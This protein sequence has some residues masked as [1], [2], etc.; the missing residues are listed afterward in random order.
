MKNISPQKYSLSLDMHRPYVGK[1]KRNTLPPFGFPFFCVYTQFDL[2][3]LQSQG[4]TGTSTT[5]EMFL[6]DIFIH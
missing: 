3:Q 5:T 1:E 4:I 2:L 6:K